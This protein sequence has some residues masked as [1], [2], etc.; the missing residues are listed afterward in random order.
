M[1]KNVFCCWGI[2]QIRIY[3]NNKHLAMFDFYFC[4]VMQVCSTWG[5]G[6]CTKTSNTFL[7]NFGYIFIVFY[8]KGAVTL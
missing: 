1:T 6:S 7:I 8:G 2:L 3:S 4:E 5:H